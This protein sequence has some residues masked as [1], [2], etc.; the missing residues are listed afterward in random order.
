M[1]S[2]KQFNAA[3]ARLQDALTTSDLLSM[4]CHQLTKENKSNQHSAMIE[5]LGGLSS[6]F[7]DKAP[8]DRRRAENYLANTLYGKNH[9]QI[10][11]LMNGNH[12]VKDDEFGARAEMYGKFIK[13]YGSSA[14]NGDDELVDQHA[15]DLAKRLRAI[16][17]E[18][19]KISYQG[20]N[21]E[22]DKFDHL[23]QYNVLM[24][25]SFLDLDIQVEFIFIRD[26]RDDALEPL[27]DSFTSVTINGMTL[28]EYGNK[29]GCQYLG[30]EHDNASIWSLEVLFSGVAFGMAERGSHYVGDFYCSDFPEKLLKEHKWRL[31]LD[32]KYIADHLIKQK[33]LYALESSIT[34][35]TEDRYSQDI[36][37][38]VKGLSDRTYGNNAYDDIILKVIEISTEE[39][40]EY[41]IFYGEVSFTIPNT[42]VVI[43]ILFSYGNEYGKNTLRQV[44]IMHK[45][46]TL[47]SI[48]K[49][50]G[51]SSK[52][53]TWWYVP[54]N[55]KEAIPYIHA[56]LQI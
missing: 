43:S 45:N 49:P 1:L 52:D 28:E 22:V 32:R 5:Q 18:E 35:E 15:N 41:I 36:K 17:P 26:E 38:S 56:L 11:H 42:G 39:F 34:G 24:Y 8:L 50:D 10:A 9:S 33:L 37:E 4:L 3:T 25:V 6:Q 53:S 46:E 51:L 12:L 54:Y 29:L 23:Y 40:E 13:N 19:F 31:N 44:E 55:L 30:D 14:S 47:I 20:Y 7:K 2:K 27:E 48:S 16:S 21:C